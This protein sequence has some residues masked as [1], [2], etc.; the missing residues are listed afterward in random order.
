MKSHNAPS[1]KARQ[2]TVHKGGR[3]EAV[4]Y[5]RVSSKEQKE[6]GFSIP[7]QR[8]LLIAYGIEKGLEIVAEFEDNE[9]AK[10]TGRTGFTKL[11]A[12]LKSRPSCRTLLV[13]KTDRVSRNMKDWSLIEDLEIATHFVREAAIFSRQAH[14]SVRT[15]QRIK[16]ILAQSY[17]ENLSEEIRKGM[18]EKCEQ[19]AFPSAAPTGYSNRAAENEKADKKVGIVPHPTY[20]PIVQLLF[21][22]AGTGLYS[23]AELTAEARLLGLRSRRGRELAKDT[24][25]Q[26]ILRN[27]V[28]AGRFR[29]AGRMYEGN[30]EPLI[31]PTLFER[32]QAIL[33][34]RSTAK[35]KRTYTFSGV[36][37]CQTCVGLLTGDEKVKRLATGKLKNYVY[38]RCAGT[39]ACRKFYTE[40]A[41]E[42]FTKQLLDSLR[43]DHGAA[44]WL[45][46]ELEAKHLTTVDTERIGR[47]KTEKA[48]LKKRRS[49]AYDHFQDGA[50]DAEMFA[51]KTAGWKTEIDRIH[52]EISKMENMIPVSHLLAAA[53]KPVELLQVASHLWDTRQPD[54]KLRLLKTMVSNYT[55]IDGSITASMRKP[56]DVLARGAENR[57]WWS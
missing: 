14:S 44:E 41:F 52:A 47:L 31:S 36:V 34:G 53:R 15:T 43:I 17:S 37:R 32:V 55:V 42:T 51:E 49:Q 45:Y 3:E 56:F 35:G 18:T 30:Y 24:I 26:C 54:E 50:L 48:E 13:E 33:D 7:A 4:I 27:P 25:L 21:E 11:V 19:G 39:K 9:T 12:F 40:K 6:T 46:R 2:S 22:K 20:G 29:W 8:K 57:E 23:A 28:Y 10:S 1:D 5:I 38:Y 16:L